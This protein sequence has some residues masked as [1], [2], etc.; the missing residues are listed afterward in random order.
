E[1]TLEDEWN[2]WYITEH[3]DKLLNLPGFTG[4]TRY[5]AVGLDDSVQYLT[6]WGLEHTK[7]LDSPEYR[8]VRGGT[9]PEKFEPY[10]SDWT[11]TVYEEIAARGAQPPTR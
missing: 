4:T 1:P 11:R 8:A 9:W 5:R 7:V 3:A 10:V 2:E 6:I